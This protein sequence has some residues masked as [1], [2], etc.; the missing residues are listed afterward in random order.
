M[1]ADQAETAVTSDKPDDEQ[2]PGTLSPD[3][4]DDDER[5]EKG[6]PARDAVNPLAPP[7][8]IQGGS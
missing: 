7:V 8:N 1:A 6:E 2:A 3:P 5:V 4:A